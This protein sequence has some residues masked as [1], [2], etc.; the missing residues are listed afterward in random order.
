M[1]G[2]ADRAE[3][4]QK[5][6]KR[7]RPHGRLFYAVCRETS[8]VERIDDL[9]RRVIAL[10]TGQGSLREALAQN[11]KLTT[12]TRDNTDSIIEWFQ[13]YRASL[14]I[15]GRVGVFTK[16]AAGIGAAIATIYAVARGLKS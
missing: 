4:N 8:N 10:E 9:E 11:T 16:W 15:L 1:Q 3:C 14:R 13:D 6:E 5:Q 7:G 12:E 2:A